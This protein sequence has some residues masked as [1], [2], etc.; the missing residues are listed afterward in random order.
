MVATLMLAPGALQ[1]Q[2]TVRHGKEKKQ[3]CHNF[4]QRATVG[5]L[6]VQKSTENLN[7]YAC[8]A[9][10]LPSVRVPTRKFDESTT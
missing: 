3:R 7:K 1:L 4:K 10:T 5:S 2:V 8:K 6:K 9:C